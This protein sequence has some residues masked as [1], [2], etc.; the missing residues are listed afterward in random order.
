MALETTYASRNIGDVFYTLRKDGVLN[1]AVPCDGGEFNLAD[2]DAGSEINN[3][4]YLIINDRLPV[5]NY[6][7]YA[8]QIKNTGSCGSFG[9]DEVNGKFKVPTVRNVYVRA[10]DNATLAK[11][12]SPSFS[13][14]TSVTVPNTGWGGGSCPSRGHA[15]TRGKIVV[16]SGAREIAEDLES[17]VES[18]VNVTAHG[19]VSATNIQPASL[20]LRPMVQLV[21]VEGKSKSDDEPSGPSVTY[22]VPYIFVPGTEAKAL[23]VNA[24]FEYVLQALKDTTGSAE[25]VVHLGRD[26]IIDGQKT[27]NKAIKTK[28][29][30]IFPATG[31]S[32]WIDFHYNG[33]ETD[34]TAR[35]FE[36]VQG[37]LS[38]SQSPASSDS[39]RKIATTEWVNSK[40]SAATGSTSMGG[41][42]VSWT[43]LPNGLILQYGVIGNL[44][45]WTNWGWAN[46]PTAFPN[47]CRSMA[48][49]WT[50]VQGA[51]DKGSTCG[52]QW[53]NSAFGY[54]PRF[55]QG[56]ANL[57]WIA[58]GN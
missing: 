53:N 35:L 37:Y 42:V 54:Y 33:S 41:N 34:Y 49:S 10:G 24:N 48:V 56:T 5:V 15:I 1:G 40:I 7:E 13:G 43:R 25:D 2:F 52:V 31:S 55:Q 12:L 8:N 23:E 36:E 11:Y 30:E 18:T 17:L 28:G 47:A 27:F 20:V 32:G 46:F 39:S 14:T 38:V 4:P 9:Y 6:V 16:G 58:I 19:S 22:K 3:L 50:Y 51:G 29:I 57:H 21:T 44:G 45:F 26:E